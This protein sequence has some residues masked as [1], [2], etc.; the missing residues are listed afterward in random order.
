MNTNVPPLEDY[1]QLSVGAIG[2]RIRVLDQ[3][4]LEQ[5]LAYEQDHADRPAVIQ[6]IRARSAALDRGAEPAAGPERGFPPADSGVDAPRREE[7]STDAPPSN[8]P[9]HGD[10][11]NPS[12]PR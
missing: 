9:S 12:Q 10:P 7:A 1:D 4:G 3:A 6:V 2:E 11:T 8:P 5:L